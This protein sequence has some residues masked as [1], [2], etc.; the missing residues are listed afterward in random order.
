MPWFGRK[1]ETADF[2]TSFRQTAE[3]MGVRIVSMGAEGAVLL[4]AGEQ[5]QVGFGNI[6]PRFEQYDPKDRVGFL[7]HVLKALSEGRSEEP[8]TL[9][10]VRD[11]LMPRVGAPWGDMGKNPP[12]AKALVPNVVDLGLVVDSEHS[13]HYVHEEDLE[14]WAVGFDDLFPAAMGNLRRRSSAAA[15]MTFDQAPGVLLYVSG[16]SYDAARMLVLR[17]LLNPWPAEGAIV[18]VPFRDQLMCVRFDGIDALKA[19]QGMIPVLKGAHD[20]ESYKISDQLFWF[21]GESWEPIGV[22]YEKGNLAI[23]PGARFTGALERFARKGRATE[24]GK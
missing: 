5:V 15:W 3:R 8:P 14:R 22:K 1:K 17:E 4:V 24:P 12:A 7:E 11:R 16:D 23:Q 21:D 10:A 6:R 18:G 13:V 19:I 20:T 9:D 2:E